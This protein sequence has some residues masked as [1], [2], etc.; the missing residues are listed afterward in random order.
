[1]PVQ[2]S[3]SPSPSPSWRRYQSGQ[4]LSSIL[5]RRDF[6]PSP[7]LVWTLMGPP[8]VHASTKATSSS[9]L[10][11][12]PFVVTSSPQV[13]TSHRDKNASYLL[14]LEYMVEGTQLWSRYRIPFRISLLICWL[15]ASTMSISP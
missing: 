15:T 14:V 13:D 5:S 3:P 4:R 11:L 10:L 8:S 1:M 6:F 2:P 9:R 12:M 7:S